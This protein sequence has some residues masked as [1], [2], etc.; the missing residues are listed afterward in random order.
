M[1]ENVHQRDE[2][3]TLSLTHSFTSTG[4]DERTDTDLAALRNKSMGSATVAD[5]TPMI[6][7]RDQS[8]E[9]TYEEWRDFLLFHPSTELEELIQ[10]W[11][12]NTCMDFGEDIGVPDD[13]S[14]QDIISGMWWRHLMAGG[15][16]GMVSRS[17]TAPLDRLK[18]F[19]QVH[20]GR[21]SLRIID[22]LR[23]MVKEGGVTGLW[24]GN[25]IN[26]IKIAPESALKF[27]AYDFIKRL[28][29]NDE[30]R[31]LKLYERFLAGSLAGG[32]SQSV[33]YPLEVMKTRLA[34]RKTNEINGISDCARQ[35][36]RIEGIRGFY[37][38]YIPN[39]LG[40]LPYAGID[41]AVYETLK[42]HYLSEH[43][44]DGTSFPAVSLLAFGT[45]SS[46]CGQVA[47]YPL[48]LVRTKLQSQAGLNLNLPHEQ[49]HAVGLFRYTVRTEGI[50]GLYRGIIPNFCKVAPAVSISY[51][52]YER[53][54]EYLGVEM[55]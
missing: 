37:R 30:D 38:G 10:K 5:H 47:A 13:F 11:R 14:D 41:L 48:A 9:I 16:A 27:A 15:V 40:I 23:Y 20:G 25:G 7:Y 55:I 19:L 52:V 8:M 46:C 1:D 21:K 3:A 45:F 34:L 29:R 49:T 22:T 43:Y 32:V 31:D 18:I 51:Y 24:R 2:E 50:K 54:R 35:L 36:F 17:C 6:N 44:M 28:I 53:T 26:V 39:L 42:R 12:H 33:I 4:S